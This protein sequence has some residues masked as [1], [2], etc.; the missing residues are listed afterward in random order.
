[1]LYLSRHPHTDEIRLY[2]RSADISVEAWISQGIPDEA[3]ASNVRH[4]PDWMLYV[5]SGD[6]MTWRM[7]P[8]RLQVL[9]FLRA[10]LFY[11]Y[12]RP[13]F[14]MSFAQLCALAHK[15]QPTSYVRRSVS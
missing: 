9:S 15:E 13:L 6:H 11:R 3:Y 4:G 1:M 14:I 7:C 5:R 8:E 2:I 10:W 12:R